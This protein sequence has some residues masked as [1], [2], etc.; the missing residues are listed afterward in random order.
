MTYGMIKQKGAKTVTRRVAFVSGGGSGLGKATVRTLL[1]DGWAVAFTYHESEQSAQAIVDESNPLGY[2]VFPIKADLLCRD[3]AESAAKSAIAHFGQID[4]FVHN[5]G[6][7]VF[8]RK[9]LAEY[10]EDDFEKMLTGNIRVFWWLY[11]HF[12]PGMR[13]GQFG[14]IVT[15]GSDGAGLAMG[16]S[17]RAAYAAAKAGLAS[18]TRSVAREERQFGITANMVCP[19]DIRGRNKELTADERAGNE[20]VGGDVSRMVAFYCRESS[21]ELNGTVTEVN[22]GADIRLRD[23]ENSVQG[24]NQNGTKSVDA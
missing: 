1:A 11:R 24:E 21:R 8:E 19:G 23:E 6:P 22:G 5:F 17:H 4:A 14:R 7:F 20:P 12:V 10:S 15:F 3:S 9:R 18:L 13:A 2:E 16:W